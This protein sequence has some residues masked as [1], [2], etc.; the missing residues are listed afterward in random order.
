[1]KTSD[2]PLANS[3]ELLHSFFSAVF[4]PFIL[5][6]PVI[7]LFFGTQSLKFFLP[8]IFLILLPVKIA[9]FSGI[10]GSC[11]FWRRNRNIS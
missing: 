3:V 10:Y 1:M 6:I 8:L 11:P 5:E 4:L 2:R 7:S 9:L